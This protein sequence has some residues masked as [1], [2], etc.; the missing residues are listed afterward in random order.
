MYFFDQYSGPISQSTP[1]GQW[2]VS[3]YQQVAMHAW[4]K[5]PG[6]TT[7][8]LELYFDNMS[9]A[10]EK[11]TIGPATP[12]SWNIVTL[13]KVYPVFAP[14]LSIVLYN[15]SAQIDFTMRLYAACCEAKSGLASL[16]SGGR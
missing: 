3:G 9:A 7:L 1:L 2:D 15:P 11:L 6:A 12:G 13:A 4:A 16:R 8:Y 14:K 10:H 5:G